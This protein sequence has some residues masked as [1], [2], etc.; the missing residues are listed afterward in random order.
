MTP[1]MKMIRQTEDK[2]KMDESLSKN[3]LNVAEYGYIYVDWSKEL[4]G[5]PNHKMIVGVDI[6]GQ[7][8]IL[9]FLSI[10]LL[11]FSFDYLVCSCDMIFHL[12]HGHSCFFV[13]SLHKGSFL[14]GGRFVWSIRSH[15]KDLFFDLIEEVFFLDEMVGI[16]SNDHLQK[17]VGCL[18]FLQD[19]K[20]IFCLDTVDMFLCFQMDWKDEIVFVGKNKRSILVEVK[21]FSIPFH[22]VV[23][24]VSHFL[25]VVEDHW[26][27]VD[28][29]RISRNQLFLPVDTACFLQ[30]HDIN[31][32]MKKILND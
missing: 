7:Q 20:H 27:M 13:L 21:I 10:H 17:W 11:N 28:M 31:F 19:S 2:N 8:F 22:H 16:H 5:W 24:D 32:F 25:P 1:S 9:A 26:V 6:V 12:R 18:Y 3:G 4:N 15:E 23:P 14:D 29:L 30:A